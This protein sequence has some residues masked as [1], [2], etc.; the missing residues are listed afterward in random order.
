M[1]SLSRELHRERAKICEHAERFDDMLRDMTAI[2]ELGTG[3]DN[4][5]RN[6]LS[7]AYKNVVG[8]R[9]SSWRILMAVH[10]KAK[11]ED[12]DRKAKL[13]DE[14]RSKV[15]EEMER[16]CGELLALLDKQLIP[17]AKDS[18]GSVFYLKMKGDYNRY[19]S[20]IFANNATKRETASAAA[21]DAYQE[22]HTVAKEKL[23]PIDPIRL[24]L[25][26]NYSVF[27][28]EI[29]SNSSEA[30]QMAKDAFEEGVASLEEVSDGSYADTAAILQLLKDNLETWSN[31]DEH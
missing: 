22:A 10:S 29:C 14:Y 24:G 15:E 31:V 16:L 9:R 6:L 13:T 27:Y 25:V 2:A 7:V 18:S 12:S 3:L 17:N 11:E 19:L 1:G 5:E 8:E 26:L 4:E 20:E 30:C 28:Y 21:K 23:T